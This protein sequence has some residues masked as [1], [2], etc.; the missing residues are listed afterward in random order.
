AS[1]S[2]EVTKAASDNKEKFS[3]LGNSVKE[4]ENQI[5]E[6]KI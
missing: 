1:L 5:T 2:E 4:L 6:F 3:E